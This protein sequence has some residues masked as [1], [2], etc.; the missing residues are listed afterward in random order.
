[1]NTHGLE[2]SDLLE[3]VFLFK[4]DFPINS[5]GFQN[6]FGF[7]SGWWAMAIIC[8]NDIV[9]FWDCCPSIQI[10]PLQSQSRLLQP[11]G[12]KLQ[13]KSI[14]QTRQIPSQRLNI[15]G[16]ND[17]DPTSVLNYGLTPCI[18]PHLKSAIVHKMVT[19]V[20]EPWIC[21]IQLTIP[22]IGLR[23]FQE[24]PKIYSHPKIDGKVNP[25]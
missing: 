12:S 4:S 23:E 8:H 24:T 3:V 20:L 2:P 21:F 6:H 25:Y 19:V 10:S 22:G 14:W 13:T 9:L 7:Y 15:N 11:L 18:S 17:Y 1:M 16:S 5:D